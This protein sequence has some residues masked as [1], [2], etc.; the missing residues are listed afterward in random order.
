MS[1]DRTKL[2]STVALV[3]CLVFTQVKPFVR[4]RVGVGQTVE[5][6]MGVKKL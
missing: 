2:L 3:T 4:M 5:L 1:L 6:S